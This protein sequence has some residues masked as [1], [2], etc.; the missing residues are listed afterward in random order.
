MNEQPS[1][2]ISQL[3]TLWSLVHEAHD[4]LPSAEE[5]RCRLLERYYGAAARYLRAATRDP[6]E[7]EELAQ[8]FSVKLLRGDFRRADPG[9]GRFRDLLKTSLW[10]LVARR[11]RDGGRRPGSLP[12]DGP[13]PLD[14]ESPPARFAAD[15]TAC[16]RAELLARAWKSLET[17][18]VQTG[19]PLYLVLRLCADGARPTS[20]RLAE[21]LS[22]RLG[23]PVS[24]VAARQLLHRARAR[25]AKL[26]LDEV[27]QSLR[28]PTR[29]RVGEEL[30][31]LGLLSYCRPALDRFG[32][33]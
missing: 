15:V 14:E 21:E 22:T 12:E 27:A 30:A 28:E 33:A 1:D 4:G 24:A 11:A 32:G 13:E 31:D 2:H 20:L 6:H 26:L 7:A 19:R 23:R 9:R 29:D 5:A 18:Q 17:F 10:R 3:T 16:W 25:F 8:E